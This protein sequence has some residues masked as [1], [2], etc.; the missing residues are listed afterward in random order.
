MCF[1]S[2]NFSNSALLTEFLR[3]WNVLLTLV[4]LTH[5]LIALSFR[6]FPLFKIFSAQCTYSR[7]C[8]VRP[9]ALLIARSKNR[10][11]SYG[12]K[13]LRAEDEN[14]LKFLFGIPRLAPNRFCVFLPRVKAGISI[15]SCHRW[16]LPQKI[17]Q[18]DRSVQKGKR[19]DLKENRSILLRSFVRFCVVQ[20]Q[21]HWNKSKDFRATGNKVI[22]MASAFKIFMAVFSVFLI[23]HNGCAGTRVSLIL[24]VFLID[25]LSVRRIRAS[26]LSKTTSSRLI[27]NGF[28]LMSLSPIFSQNI[29]TL[30]THETNQTFPRTKRVTETATDFNLKLAVYWRWKVPEIQWCQIG[31]WPREKKEEK[32]WFISVFMLS[33]FTVITTKTKWRCGI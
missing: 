22:R 11:I 9:R 1:F 27:L 30:W 8:L 23:T 2:V 32:I 21:L 12:P 4:D 10:F 26:V 31:N 13:L 7:C 17:T 29:L 3:S 14:F 24:A 5:A 18:Q 28:S 33:A 15:T 25:G 20:H 19:R 16:D 6:H